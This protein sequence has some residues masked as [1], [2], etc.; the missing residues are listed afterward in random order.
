MTHPRGLAS[1]TR[2]FAEGATGFFETRFSLLNP[3]TTEATVL[4]RFQRDDGTQQAHY[5]RVPGRQSRKV[6]VSTEVPDMARAAFSTVIEAD[7]PIV[8]DRQMYWTR[9]NAYGSHAE[10][11]VVAPAR[12]WYLAE[13][14]TH[15]GFDLFYLVQN[16][17]PGAG[18]GACPLSAANG[19]AARE[20]LSGAGHHPADNLGQPRGIPGP[21]RARLLANTDV[22]AVVE[23]VQGPPVIVERAMY[24]STPG[25]GDFKA[26][27]ESA[28]V[29]A[30]STDWFLA[31]GA[32]GTFFDLFVLLANPTDTPTTVEATYLLSDGLAPVVRKYRL[33]AQSRRTVYVN[34]EGGPLSSAQ[35]TFPVATTV[36]S[37]DGVPFLV[38]R[39]MWWPGGFADW[40]E[41]HNAAGATTTGQQWG[42]AE[43]VTTAP[44]AGNVETYVLVANTSPVAG[45]VAVTLLFDDGGPEVTR[46]FPVGANS[47]VTVNVRGEFPEA[48]NRGFGVL[49]ESVGPQPLALV[50]ERAL[51]N[52]ANG[53]FWAAGNDA[54][55]ARLR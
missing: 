36:R 1:A 17:N 45:P 31:E 15:S 37:L 52:N 11:G 33:P 16:P 50:V 26:G 54:L 48:L 32:T 14:A 3:T 13:G 5:V 35:F 44:H 28:G 19:R 51:Y 12:T 30:P 23:V 39:A 6:T 21:G 47:R 20:D 25:L 40:Y 55:G 42:L 10:T 9:L 43:G 53:L 27:H 7:Q 24:L 4:L 29:T 8:A 46:T 41:A 38:E 2:Y 22:T 49:V 34:L 18:G